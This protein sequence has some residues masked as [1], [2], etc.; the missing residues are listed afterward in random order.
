VNLLE[1]AKRLHRESLRSGA[2]PVAIEGSTKEVLR[3]FDWISDAWYDLQI[4]PRDWKWMRR[5]ADVPLTI[6]QREYTA[7]NFALTD[8]RRWLAPSDDRCARVYPVA[9]PSSVTAL[10]P[11]GSYDRFLTDFVDV[12]PKDGAPHHWIISPTESILIAPAPDAAYRFKAAYQSKPFRLEVETDEPDMPEE[13]HL[14][15]VWRALMELASIDAATEVYVRAKANHDA[16]RSDLI[17]DQGP[18]WVM[19]GRVIA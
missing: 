5:D 7:S 17:S 9:N 10:V 14:L 19:R 6:G 3:L 13:F 15:L 11:S 1:L 2:G 12:P 18:Q 16:L 4:E 8:F